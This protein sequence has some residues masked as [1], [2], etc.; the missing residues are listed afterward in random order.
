MDW[1]VAAGQND[2]DT[3]TMLSYPRHANVQY[4]ARYFSPVEVEDH[5]SS[6]GFQ[7]FLYKTSLR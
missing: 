5:C 6:D 1:Q 4:E 2:R 7:R 3:Q